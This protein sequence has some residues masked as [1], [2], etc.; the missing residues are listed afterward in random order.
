MSYNEFII[1]NPSAA[2]AWPRQ[3]ESSIVCRFA[4]PSGQV[5]DMLPLVPIVIRLFEGPDEKSVWFSATGF[6]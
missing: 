6:V 3:F 4:K 2:S 1:N 5:K